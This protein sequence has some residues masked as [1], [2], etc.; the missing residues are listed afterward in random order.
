ME[1]TD[2]MAIVATEDG[3]LAPCWGG[4]FE[5]S[6][7]RSAVKALSWQQVDAIAERFRKLSPYRDKSRSILKIERDN[8]D[9]RT[10]RQRQV[11]CLAV[12]AKRYALFL[13]DDNGNPVLLQKG[14]NNHED[15]WSE[16]GLGHLRNPTDLR[17]ED[18]DWIRQAWLSIIRMSLRLPTEPLGFEHLPAVGRVTITSP[19]AMRSLAKLNVGKK[20]GARLKPFNFLLSCHV[21]Q[22]GHPPG[23]DPE[24][25]H[26]VAP[27]ELNSSR[28]LE[29]PGSINTLDSITELRRRASTGVGA[30]HAS[31][32][33]AMFCVNMRFIRG[34]KVPMRE[35]NRVE[36]RLSACCSGATFVLVRSFTS[37]EN[38]TCSKK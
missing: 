35:E 1:D 23:V 10:G 17:S 25:F 6:D 3:G 19:K 27:Y 2:S 9:P 21:K 26:L 7:G 11:Y 24:K 5:M 15:R 31:R 28:W 14:I 8:Y 29:M 12:S 20:Y 32:P 16:H 18:R 36:N 34:R 38:R 30:L 33:T 13:R 37:A 4:P 22:F